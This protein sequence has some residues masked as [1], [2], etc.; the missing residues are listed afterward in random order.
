VE[1]GRY[2]LVRCGGT[3]A[4]ANMKS[5]NTETP[6]CP[7]PREVPMRGLGLMANGTALAPTSGGAGQKANPE[8]SGQD[9]PALP[10]TPASSVSP[11]LASGTEAPTHSVPLGPG[12]AGTG[13]PPFSTP[14]GLATAGTGAVCGTNGLTL[15]DPGKKME[16]AEEVARVYTPSKSPRKQSAL[17]QQQYLLKKQEAEILGLQPPLWNPCSDQEADGVRSQD[18]P[19]TSQKESDGNESQGDSP[20]RQRTS[21]PQNGSRKRWNRRRR[22]EKDAGGEESKADSPPR[23]TNGS[24]KR[25]R[26]RSKAAGGSGANSSA[27]PSAAAKRSLVPG[28]TPEDV[29]FT[30]KR[31]EKEP[32]DRAS[33]S[34]QGS[35]ED[36]ARAAKR[37]KQYA[38]MVRRGLKVVV[39]FTETPF[40]DITQEVAEHF[41]EQ[42]IVGIDAL[43]DGAPP[44]QFEGSGITEDKRF[45]IT[46]NNQASMEWVLGLTISDYKD[47]SVKVSKLTDL[48]R[49]V[50]VFLPGSHLHKTEDAILARLRKQ[51]VGL[52]TDLWRVIHR[53]DRTNPSVGRFMVLA[54]DQVSLQSLES[55][56][57]SAFYELTKVHFSHGKEA[58][59]APEKQT[60]DTSK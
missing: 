60:E 29:R 57:M 32:R 10:G 4:K 22:N 54:I 12:S 33:T 31:P 46:C 45:L 8:L 24:V 1:G 39:H 7:G 59:S 44:P 47:R 15:S 2:V 3:G 23:K 56:G 51:N 50:K 35:A 6:K 38:S 16:W 30:P 21:S 48:E 53:S 43:P 28:E 19:T 42:I 58:P 34:A 55:N 40:E 11:G 14:P 27:T 49:S 26:R 20:T 18:E 52:K 17:E 36:K 37:E 9:G 41:R 25:K 5:T 13:T